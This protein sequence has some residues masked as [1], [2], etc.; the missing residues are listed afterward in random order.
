MS[1]W[2]KHTGQPFCKLHQ[3]DEFQRGFLGKREG[4]KEGERERERES[5]R[6]RE[7]RENNIEDAWGA[8][9]TCTWWQSLAVSTNTTTASTTPTLYLFLPSVV[10]HFLLSNIKH[11]K[12]WHLRTNFGNQQLFHSFVEAPEGSCI[13]S[14]LRMRMCAKVSQS[15]LVHS[16]NSAG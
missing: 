7:K 3:F 16:L 2:W 12:V 4:G 1:T 15:V 8:L 11:V 14:D 13:Q 6:A 10:R 9:V 5:E